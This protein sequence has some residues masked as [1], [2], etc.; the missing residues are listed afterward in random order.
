MIQKI[1]RGPFLK[2]ECFSI[3]QKDETELLISFFQKLQISLQ[4][5]TLNLIHSSAS[6]S[7][8]ISKANI[9]RTRNPNMIWIFYYVNKIKFYQISWSI[10]IALR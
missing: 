2:L 1:Q 3:I 7:T 9:K 8:H 10:L 6:T 5:P 4:K